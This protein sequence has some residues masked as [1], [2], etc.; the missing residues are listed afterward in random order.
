MDDV[1]QDVVEAILKL[2]GLL[3]SMQVPEIL[4]PE[5]VARMLRC[6]RRTVYSLLDLWTESGGRDGLRFFFMNKKRMVRREVVIGWIQGQE[7]E[8][9]GTTLTSKVRRRAKAKA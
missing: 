7:K 3:K 1:N 5:E 8:S 6:S 9:C 4:V 2:P